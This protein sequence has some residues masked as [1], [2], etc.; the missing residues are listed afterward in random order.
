MH[1]LSSR[2]NALFSFGGEVL[3]AV[4]V[5]SALVSLLT[6]RPEVTAVAK[7]TA[8]RAMK[9]YSQQDYYGHRVERVE[10]GL[11]IDA[12]L[13]GL[14]TWNTKQVYFGVVVHYEGTKDS[15]NNGE[16]GV[17]S[18]HNEII[19]WDTVFSSAREAVLHLR[20]IKPKYYFTGLT[21]ELHGQ[22]I[23][24]QPMWM[25]T[26]YAGTLSTVYGSPTTYTLPTNVERL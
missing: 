3:A 23:V 7:I 21:S 16:R 10:L 9:I 19:L 24:V 11:D 22:K 5:A 18:K 1:D 25:V 20:D 26:P 8:N 13:S 17:K 14:F 12:D 6:Q 4:A 15:R 2:A